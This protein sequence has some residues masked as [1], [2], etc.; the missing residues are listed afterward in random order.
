[1]KIQDPSNE[2]SFRP[3]DSAKMNQEILDRV[4]FYNN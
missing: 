3:I 2:S 1:L 4:D